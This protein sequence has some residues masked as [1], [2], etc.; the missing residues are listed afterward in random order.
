MVRYGVILKP[1]CNRL[2][3]PHSAPD[4]R[5]TLDRIGGMQIARCL[6]LKALGNR[7][8]GLPQVGVLFPALPSFRD[9]GRDVKDAA[10]VLM[11]VP[12][13]PALARPRKPRHLKVTV[14]NG[15]WRRHF[16]RAHNGNSHRA[17]VDAAA[18]LCRRNALDSMPANFEA[19]PVATIAV[20][21]DCDL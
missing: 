9:A 15:N 4:L 20:N 16:I 19:E 11:L 18:L 17:C 3:T 2:V 10:R 13:L 5:P 1:D 14:E 6:L 21:F 12:M 8:F 7:F